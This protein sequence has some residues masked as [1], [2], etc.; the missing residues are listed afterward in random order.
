[1]SFIC[2][3]QFC[4]A[5]LEAEKSMIGDIVKCPRCHERI[6]IKEQGDNTPDIREQIVTMF[7]MPPVTWPWA[8]SL[9]FKITVAALVIDGLLFGF[10]YGFLF[11]A[12][13]A[14]H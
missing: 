3:C 6:V 10:I 4:G 9:V 2:V 13:V 8:F 14:L 7:A 11:L 1:M 12:R 5:E